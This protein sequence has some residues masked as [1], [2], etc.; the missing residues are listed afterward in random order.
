MGR[1]LLFF[2]LLFFINGCTNDNKNGATT[3]LYTASI[4]ISSQCAS[5]KITTVSSATDRPMLVVLLSYKNVQISSDL[6]TWASKIFGKRQGELNNYYR[7]ISQNQFEFSEATECNGIASVSLEKNHPNIDINKANFEKI[8]YPDLALALNELKD[9][10]SFNVYDNN[11][12]GYIS[13]D[14]LLIT[15]IVA[16]YE[17]AYEGKH[18]TNGIWAHQS[19]V[20]NSIAPLINGVSLLNCSGRGNFALFGE[21]HDKASPHDATIGIIAHELGHSTFNLPDLYLGGGIGA[22]GL[23]GA[24]VWAYANDT[25][26]PGE[27]PAHMSAWSKVYNRWVTPDETNGTKVLNAT[28]L[29]SY[30]VVKVQNG[31]KYYLLENRDNSGYDKGLSFLNTNNAV[32]FNGG[33]AIWEID[34]TQTTQIHLDNNSVNSDANHQGVYI[35]DAKQGGYLNNGKKG[36]GET[37]FYSGNIDALH[38]ADANI[39]QISTQGIT[40]TLHI[41]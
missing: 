1:L 22:F 20:D 21:K 6:T 14:E 5:S 34:D 9:K 12:D 29:T 24:G 25:Q 41:N 40:M 32:Q 19:C 18:V 28:S 39:S 11:G 8:V 27:S 16:G 38:T 4:P 37:L 23:M 31:S 13:K 3:T 36:K 35:V 26:Y 10:I 17:D 2:L 7:E 33:V 15:F 30:N